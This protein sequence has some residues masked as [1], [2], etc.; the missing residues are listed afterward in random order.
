MQKNDNKIGPQ[1]NLIKLP[2]N[3]VFEFDFDH[4]TDWVKTLLLEMNENATDKKPE[5]YLQETFLRISGEVEKKNKVEY[6]EYLTVRGTIEA[7]YA[8]ECVRTLKPMKVQ[9]NLEFKVCFI[10]ESLATSEHF[11]DI[12]ETYMDNDVYEI[13]FYNKRTVDFLEMIHE[14]IYLNYEQYPILDAD[15]RLLGVDWRNP[16]KT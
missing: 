6:S 12:D 9:M 8:T 16:A 3:A 14:Q 10:D 5:A 2:S 13:Y 15:A 4:E 11:A 1:I 7:E